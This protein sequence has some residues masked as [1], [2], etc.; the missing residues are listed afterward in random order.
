MAVRLPIV[1]L[2]TA[3]VFITVKYWGIKTR[4]DNCLLSLDRQLKL[5]KSS[6]DELQ[7]TKD[8]CE[9]QMTEKDMEI[10]LVK[11]DRTSFERKLGVCEQEKEELV[12]QQKKIEEENEEVAKD[13]ESVLKQAN[14]DLS[15][16]VE[17][18]SKMKKEYERA[19]ASEVDLRKERD[20]LKE[21]KKTLEEEVK[22]AEDKSAKMLL[23]AKK[24][25][26]EMEE[27]KEELLKQKEMLNV[28][29]KKDDKNGK[30]LKPED[31]THFY[32]K[33]VIKS[34]DKEPKRD[35]IDQEVEEAFAKNGA[36]PLKN[37]THKE[38]GNDVKGDHESDYQVQ[39]PNLGVV[40][41]GT[42]VEEANDRVGRA[43]KKE[44]GD[45]TD[46]EA[47]HQIENPDFP[48]DNDTVS[49]EGV[50][51]EDFEE[52]PLDEEIEGG[53]AENN[54]N[55][56][57]TKDNNNSFDEN[58]FDQLEDEENNQGERNP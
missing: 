39:E 43:Q 7:E 35:I 25:K 21:E 20:G 32:E 55:N 45:D 29:A 50:Q 24:Y 34:N 49:D 3:L 57:P 58:E 46:D 12:S 10:G 52:A 5:V 17:K 42:L 4:Q 19:L 23:K 41:N 31:D 37:E 54:V 47:V 30:N 40:E 38:N 48:G 27:A 18:Y 26:T 1:L 13:N 22:A 16:L 14:D 9:R 53:H 28:A 33:K 8:R 44:V 11:R 2:L 6:D 15:E 36:A 56:N 51:G